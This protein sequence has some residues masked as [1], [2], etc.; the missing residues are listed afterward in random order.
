[1]TTTPRRVALGLALLA[2]AAASALTACDTD[3]LTTVNDNPNSPTDAPP[4]PLFTSAVNS[5]VRRWMGGYNFT[6]TSAVV[7][8]LAMNQYTDE[9]RYAGLR[10]SATSGNFDGAYANE[11]QD[12][13]Q[14]VRKGQAL[15][16]PGIHGPARVLQTWEFGVMTDAFGDIPY[17]D[18]LRGDSGTLAPKY[19][20]QKDIY[21]GLFTTLAAAVTAMS[22]GA[23]GPGLGN[24]DPIY[25][26][27]LLRWQ[28]FANSLRAR[29]A[30]QLVNVDR[31]KAETELRAALAAPG[32]VL[33]SNA[34]NARLVWPGDGVN[35]NP[36]AV[37]LKTRDDRRMSRT[38][39]TV[40]L[41][42]NDPRTAVFAQPVVD[43]SLYRG[44]FGG[45]PNGL[46]ADSAGKWTRL[47]SRPGAVFFPG[48]TT[49]GTYGSPAGL[50]T[51]SYLMTYAEVLFIQAEAAERGLAGLAAAQAPALYRQ[52]VTASL[53]QWG[54]AAPSAASAFLAQPDVAYKGGADGLRQIALQKWVALFSNGPQAWAEWRRT[55]QPATIRPG[56]AAIVSYVPRRFYYSTGEA[57]VNA[58]R[59][60]EAIA[61][62]GPDDFKTRVYW[63]KNPTA[64]PTY[65]DAATCGPTS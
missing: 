21:A 2:S 61:R 62:Q 40:L 44:G 49:Y 45:M 63:D 34:D 4:G 23:G 51:P 43:S 26:G 14:I 11:L 15:N 50:S 19:D 1:M 36:W 54:I 3:S 46:L 32:G 41:G 53:E 64:A 16:A 17:S 7:Q 12:L 9:D 30:L 5:G 65:V 18:A 33:Q 38:L 29:Y 58:D 25:G 57:S 22:G 48:V 24:A 56:P 59:L 55:C 13:R 52:A 28:R 35:D 6:Q 10:A 47:A 8:H 31:A 39:M 20:A 37:T 42:T 27:D 60:A